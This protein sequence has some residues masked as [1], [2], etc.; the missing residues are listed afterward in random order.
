MLFLDAIPQVMMFPS[1]W[2]FSTVLKKQSR[3]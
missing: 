2:E 1:F 3:P